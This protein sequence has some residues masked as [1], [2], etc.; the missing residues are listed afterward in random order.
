MNK[1]VCFK[2]NTNATLRIET[3]I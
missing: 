3:G 2:S 1:I